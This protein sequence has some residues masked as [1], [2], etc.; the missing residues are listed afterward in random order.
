MSVAKPFVFALMSSAYG[1][2]S[3]TQ[4]VGLNATGRAFNSVA[5]IE[6]REDGGRSPGQPRGDG[7]RQYGSRKHHR[8]EVALHPR[9]TLEVRGPGPVHRRGG[10]RLGF[11]V[12]PDQPGDRG[13]AA[14]PRPV[15]GPLRGAVDLYTRQSCLRVSAFDLATMAATLAAGG[16]HPSTGEQV[17][18]QASCRSALVVMATAG[19]YET[20]GEWLYTI[21]LPGKSGIGGGIVMVSPGRVVWGRS[22]LGWMARGTASRVSSLPRHFP[23]TSDSTC[24]YPSPSR[25]EGLVP[26]ELPD[27]FTHCAHG[28]TGARTRRDRR[29]RRE[30]SDHR[31]HGGDQCGRASAVPVQQRGDPDKAEGTRDQEPERGVKLTIAGGPVRCRATRSATGVIA[32]APTNAESTPPKM[33]PPSTC[34]A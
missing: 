10:G 17:V 27:S 11:G 23:S 14:Q 32:T 26:Y 15:E 30:R 16:I 24:S 28:R 12:E 21:G 13:P 29:G 3:V 9:G 22:H 25:A 1:P 5:A 34:A 6:D 19:L 4:F 31:L 18:D 20:S 33:A 7:D 8:R 2:D